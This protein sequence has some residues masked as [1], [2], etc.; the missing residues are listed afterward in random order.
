M[1]QI[2]IISANFPPEDKAHNSFV[3]AIP[4]HE[5]NRINTTIYKT[6]KVKKIE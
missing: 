6:K 3:K 2:K 4:A 5:N 1:I